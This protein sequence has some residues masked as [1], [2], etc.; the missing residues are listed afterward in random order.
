MR[1]RTDEAPDPDQPYG[2][3][4]HGMITGSTILSIGIG[5]ILLYIAVRG[6]SLWLGTWSVGLVLSSVVYLIGDAAGWWWFR[7]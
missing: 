3:L 1:Y 4:V 2:A 5:A 7:I 6:R